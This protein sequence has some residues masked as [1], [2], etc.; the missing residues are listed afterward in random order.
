MS[1]VRVTLYPPI[2]SVR[3]E[4]DLDVARVVGRE[5]ELPEE[6]YVQIRHQA[7]IETY[8]SIRRAAR[9]YCKQHTDDFVASL[10]LAFSLTGEEP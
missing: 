9:K 10:Q 6:V 3:P 2:P 5:Y 7:K 1:T 8:S 4:D